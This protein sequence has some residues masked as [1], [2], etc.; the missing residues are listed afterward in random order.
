MMCR[1]PH[2]TAPATH[3]LAGCTFE[4]AAYSMSRQGVDVQY[5][6]EDSSAS[7]ELAGPIAAQ[8]LKTLHLDSCLHMQVLLEEAARA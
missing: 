6:G 7:L 5:F 8:P 2:A 4:L 1:M 3:T